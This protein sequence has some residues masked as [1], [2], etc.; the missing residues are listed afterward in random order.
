MR[1]RFEN[2]LEYPEHPILVLSNRECVLEYPGGSNQSTQVASGSSR[3]LGGACS[4]SGGPSSCP[5]F[6]RF[7]VRAQSTRASTP[8]I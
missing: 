3:F 2:P 5:E 4:N 1:K 7:R 6:Q 8:S